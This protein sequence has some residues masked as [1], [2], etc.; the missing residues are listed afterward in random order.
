MSTVYFPNVA[1]KVYTSFLLYSS[2]KRI[3]SDSSMSICEM[4]NFQLGRIFKANR[5]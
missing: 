1:V 5:L 3:Y 4:D 2:P